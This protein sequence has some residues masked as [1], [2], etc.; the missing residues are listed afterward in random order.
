[1]ETKQILETIQMISEEKLDIR[2]ITMG[3]SLFDCID[4]DGQKAR[5]KFM[6]N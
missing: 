4:G 5:Q 1:M 6:I 2:T 3:I